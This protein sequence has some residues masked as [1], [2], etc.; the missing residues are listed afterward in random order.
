VG[1]LGADVVTYRL[2]AKTSRSPRGHL[3]LYQKHVR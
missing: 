1:K 3:I 2:K